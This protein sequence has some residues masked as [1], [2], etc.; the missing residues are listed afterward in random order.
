VPARGTRA[1]VLLIW[2]VAVWLALV[3][4]WLTWTPFELTET[5]NTLQL[6][7]ET[8][9]QDVAGN[10]L[11]LMPFGAIIAL[12]GGRHPVMRAAILAALLSASLELGQIW[13]FGRTASVWD[14]VLNTAG[15]GVAAY[16][17]V[18]LTTRVRASGAAASIAAA[19]FV[20]IV[21]YVLHASRAY[22]EGMRLADWDESFL[23]EAG[24]E[25]GGQRRYIGEASDARICAGDGPERLCAGSNAPS[26]TRALITRVAER[27]QVVEVEAKVRSGAS[28]HSHLA[29]IVTFSRG[30][31]E[32]NITLG[33]DG[34]SLV[35]RLRTP[36]N[37]ANGRDNE[38]VTYGALPLGVPVAIRVRYDH[39]RVTTRLETPQ[40]TRVV[41]HIFDGLAAPLLVRGQGP[42]T[43]VQSARARKST[44]AVLVI[45]LLLAGIWT[46]GRLRRS[47]AVE[48]TP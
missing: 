3:A 6:F 36:M 2:S 28:V 23:I 7:P 46:V 20:V 32:R 4:A 12:C 47:P 31:F 39:G 22:A 34:K 27:S 8:G 13:I 21:A 11:L 18:R 48:P 19:V 16:V 29:R 24:D 26:G 30:P 15:A 1:A 10:I 37:G 45:P 9:V 17:V 43:Q 33:Q 41:E 25:D 40:R 38:L 14:V 44:M 5:R 35:L 42:V